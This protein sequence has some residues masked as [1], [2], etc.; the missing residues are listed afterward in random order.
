M[1]NLYVINNGSALKD[2]I[3]DK[4]LKEFHRNANKNRTG[5]MWI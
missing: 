2:F 1:K 5:N 4:K 3:D